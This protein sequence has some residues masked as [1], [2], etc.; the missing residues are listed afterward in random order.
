MV[1]LRKIN[2][3]VIPALADLVNGEVRFLDEEP[4]K[5]SFQGQLML[6]LK[7]ALRAHGDFFMDLSLIHI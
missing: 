3:S 1:V 5:E 6:A 7:R 2:D 4:E